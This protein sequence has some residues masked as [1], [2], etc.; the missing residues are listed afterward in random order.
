MASK[1]GVKDIDKQKEVENMLRDMHR[2]NRNKRKEPDKE[3][4][5]KII[6]P[7]PNQPQ[8]PSVRATC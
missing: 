7:N 1:K 8:Q 6:V 3:K 4:Q 2:K 5:E